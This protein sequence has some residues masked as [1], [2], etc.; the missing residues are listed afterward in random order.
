MAN[1]G[2][3]AN[4]IAAVNGRELDGRALNVNEARPKT[5]RASGGGGG[6]ARKR[7]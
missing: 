5:D 2:E 6:G 3:A 4:A 1:D 7:W